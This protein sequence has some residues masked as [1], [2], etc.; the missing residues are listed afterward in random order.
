MMLVLVVMRFDS[1][2]TEADAVRSLETRLADLLTGLAANSGC[3]RGWLAC[4]PDDPRI[5][6]V[7][8]TW[9][10]IG[11]FRRALSRFEVKVA[12]GNL[13]G[14]SVDQPSVFEVIRSHDRDGLSEHGTDRAF[15]ADTASP[16]D[17]QTTRTGQP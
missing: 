3:E 16:S 17:N 6:V 14:E 1:A 13:A 4:S 11:S 8:T 9:R 10:N 5:W 2:T 15:D 12:M 7:T